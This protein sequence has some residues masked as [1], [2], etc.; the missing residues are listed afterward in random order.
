M[1]LLFVFTS[2]QSI[3]LNHTYSAKNSLNSVFTYCAMVCII[4][5]AF[6]FSYSR[7][8]EI[9]IDIQN[10]VLGKSVKLNT[11]TKCTFFQSRVS[12]SNRKHYII[13]SS[14]ESRRKTDDLFKNNV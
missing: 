8:C 4:D 12:S 5:Y 7:N 10:K 9:T 13:S 3:C 11:S 1:A 14:D 2:K 6:N